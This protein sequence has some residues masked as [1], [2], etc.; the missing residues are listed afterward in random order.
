MHGGLSHEDE[1]MAEMNLI[2]LI[3]IALTLVIILMVSTVFI[4][5]PGVNLKLPQTVTREGAPETPKDVTVAI[6]ADG[7]VYLDGE[8]R[9][10]AELQA[11]LKQV[12]GKNKQARV[13]VKGDRDV[14]YSRVM[15]VMDQVRQA[16][17][18]RVVLP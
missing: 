3:D 11:H 1:P 8:K 15:E 6:T 18:A 4:K 13:L 12:A 16:G 14:V 2:P 9:T 5:Q 10:A 7:G 17:L